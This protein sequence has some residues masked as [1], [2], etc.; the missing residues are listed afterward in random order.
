MRNY[1]ELYTISPFVVDDPRPSNDNRELRLGD[2]GF[3]AIYLS[4]DSEAPDL[5]ILIGNR[6][7][8]SCKSAFLLS[9]TISHHMPVHLMRTLW[10]NCLPTDIRSGG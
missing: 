8:Q 4:V 3:G 6:N 2:R 5:C 1:L 9:L 10:R 7:L